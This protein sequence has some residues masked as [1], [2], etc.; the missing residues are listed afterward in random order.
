MLRP[1][2]IA[3]AGRLAVVLRGVRG[4]ALFSR[5]IVSARAVLTRHGIQYALAAGLLC[6]VAIAVTTWLVERDAVG[7]NIDEPG[8]AFWWAMTTVTT[9]GYGDTFPV[10]AVGRGMAVVLMLVGIGLFGLLTASVAAFFVESDSGSQTRALEDQVA[11]LAG[12]IAALR[13]ELVTMVAGADRSR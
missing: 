3:R 13:E 5:A 11:R 2:R 9:A 8:T 10:T 6:C 4:V 7:A 1:L 12:E